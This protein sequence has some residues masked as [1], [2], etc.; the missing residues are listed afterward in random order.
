[1]TGSSVTDVVLLPK[2][3]SRLR[4]LARDNWLQYARSPYRWRLNIKPFHRIASLS[5]SNLGTDPWSG[6]IR[7]SVIWGIPA[8]EVCHEWHVEARV[9]TSEGIFFYIRFHRTRCTFA[10][11]GCYSECTVSMLCN[12]LKWLQ[13]HDTD[14]TQVVVYMF[15]LV[16]FII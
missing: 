9:S 1:M 7:Y 14:A 13:L 5:G 3:A 12:E 6:D 10:V 11:T 15:F 2:A 8:L 4:A 16:V